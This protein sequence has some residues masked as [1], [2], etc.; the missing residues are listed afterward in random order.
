MIT[1]KPSITIL[2]ILLLKFISIVQ[3]NTQIITLTKPSISSLL[4][5][6]ECSDELLSI[7]GLIHTTT[8][9]INRS[10]PKSICLEPKSEPHQT[11]KL[12]LAEPSFLQQ[13]ITNCNTLSSFDKSY[14][15]RISWSASDHIEINLSYDQL[16]TLLILIQSNHD[17]FTNLIGL[18]ILIEP[19]Y[20]DCLPKTS[21]P[22]I[23]S[24]LSLIFLLVYFQIPTKI[25]N[26]SRMITKDA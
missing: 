19:L 4:N 9:L 25:E 3:S 23:I 16:N 10:I 26:L 5:Q 7:P 14:T 17:S 12:P 21:I 15:A 1:P 20:F 6:N 18:D 11:Q 24:L 2:I 22:L 8:K 13:F